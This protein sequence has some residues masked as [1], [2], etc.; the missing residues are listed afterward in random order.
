MIK[1]RFAEEDAKTYEREAT[2]IHKRAKMCAIAREIG[3][4]INDFIVSPGLS[5]GRAHFA[6]E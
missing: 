6:I 5:Q 2:I 1:S 4:E 3:R